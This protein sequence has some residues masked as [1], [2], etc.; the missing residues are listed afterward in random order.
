M[1]SDTPSINGQST[2]CH[3]CQAIFSS[4]T[5]PL[6]LD[7]SIQ[8]AL[9]TTLPAAHHPTM[10]SFR[11][12]VAG[13][14][15]MC[16]VVDRIFPATV[17]QEL[18]G[19]PATKFY[20]VRNIEAST[21]DEDEPAGKHYSVAVFLNVDGL[22]KVTFFS[23][24]QVT[25]G[26]VLNVPAD[27]QHSAALVQ[28]WC[29]DCTA[30]AGKHAACQAYRDS[31]EQ[32][33]LQRP[34]HLLQLRRGGDGNVLF[35][36]LQSSET[37]ATSPA[38]ATISGVASDTNGLASL[39]ASGH[40]DDWMVAA[41]V[42]PTRLQT[43]MSL[44]LSSG[45]EYVW[46]PVL[47]PSS[48]DIVTEDIC[49]GGMFTIA[50]LPDDTADGLPDTLLPVVSAGWSANE[51]L[52]V[53][54]PAH[55]SDSLD[56]SRLTADARFHRDVLLSPAMLFSD[57]RRIWWQC[58][59]GTLYGN[60]V[61][62]GTGTGT[63]TRS[64]SIGIHG[65]H[66]ENTADWLGKLKAAVAATDRVLLDEGLAASWTSVVSKLSRQADGGSFEETASVVDGMAAH[67]QKLMP[68]SPFPPMTSSSTSLKP[69]PVYAHG[70]WSGSLVE[71]L[72]WRRELPDSETP[73]VESSSLPHRSSVSV[74]TGQRGRHIPSWSWLAVDAPVA[75]EFL[76]DLGG[77][78]GEI[79]TSLMLSDEPR[80][81]CV[82]TACLDPQNTARIEATG[83]LIPAVVDN[84]APLDNASTLLLEGVPD[85][86]ASVTWDFAHDNAP[87]ETFMWPLF[88][89]SSSETGYTS[90]R[91][92][93]LRAADDDAVASFVRYGW[94]RYSSPGGQ[95]DAN[96][97]VA[98]LG[99]SNGEAGR[100]QFSLL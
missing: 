72:A 17:E 93:L 79:C 34:S 89:E 55:F 60:A 18:P 20:L 48:Y 57:G 82:A 95:E 59:E 41:E 25:Q 100:V 86:T 33:G 6:L 21:G 19:A 28:Q 39:A 56:V 62:T 26:T 91:G 31:V 97:A 45:V 81:K 58:I 84:T 29:Q 94:V 96:N 92:L 52:V 68:L 27:G 5:Q 87:A 3:A 43:A 63:G 83:W 38:Y 64:S 75:Y 32:A 4:K 70:V 30:G 61:A 15:A 76:L 54:Q 35:R 50:I 40:L 42:L 10:Q 99:Q 65:V 90:A 46:A 77:H 2:L 71:Q 85:G 74:G 16:R 78:S 66:D 7:E 53:Y 11:D 49:A 24:A 8:L 73:T 14:C 36:L 47:C 69:P 12:A 67:V 23:A 51:Q 13:G 9:V 37:G 22:R 98:R 88:V 1:V 44:A 80:A